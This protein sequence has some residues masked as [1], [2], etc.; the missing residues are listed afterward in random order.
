MRILYYTAGVAGSGRVVQ[1]ISIYNAFKRKNL[2]FEYCLLSSSPMPRLADR[3]GV[4]HAEIPLEDE[5]QLS[6]QTWPA[7][8]LY[9]SLA[10]YRPDVLLV[11]LLWLPLFHFTREL[12]FRKVFL[13]R[14]IDARYFT[15][16]LPGGRISFR[17]DD[18]DLL[19]ATEPW[20]PPFPMR[21]INPI[22]VRNRD[23]ILDRPEALRRLGLTQR[24]PHCLF[25]FTGPAE[26]VADAKRMFAH[27]VE[28]GY[29]IVYAA[30]HP[31]GL[32][33]AV[34]YFSAFDYLI[35][36]AGY[37]SFWEAVYFR[38][39]AYF[40]PR[41]RHFEDQRLRVAECQDR[42]FDENGA[43]QLVELLLQQ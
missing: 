14:Q 39:E 8:K 20:V 10:A 2:P 1:G 28:E 13:C 36:G 32:F 16:E 5:H 33:P 9:Q 18:Y 7:S 31:A 3:F 34:D 17:P 26:D 21:S 15:I 38:K 22:V 40:L 42:Y 12:P 4:P 23:E 27:L 11:D 37:N 24:G 25:T 43:D 30:E 35:C 19:L 41:P 29:D 6:A